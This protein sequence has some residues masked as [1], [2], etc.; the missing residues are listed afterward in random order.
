MAAILMMIGAGALMVIRF[1]LAL[2]DDDSTNDGESF[3]EGYD[4][5]GN[6]GQKQLSAKDREALET[7]YWKEHK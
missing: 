4:S 1:L 5:D 6:S 7:W 2:L 3:F